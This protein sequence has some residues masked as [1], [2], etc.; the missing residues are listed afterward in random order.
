[1]NCKR[2]QHPISPFLECCFFF[3]MSAVSIQQHSVERS[4]T[5]TWVII[6]II[7]YYVLCIFITKI[8]I[9]RSILRKCTILSK[10]VH[11]CWSKAIPIFGFNLNRSFYAAYVHLPV[12]LEPFHCN[13]FTLIT[14]FEDLLVY[15][16]TL[17]DCS[18]RS[19]PTFSMWTLN[20]IQ[21]NQ[22]IFQ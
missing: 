16:N 18:S 21:C 9:Q 20:T 22:F 4:E 12:L 1:M 2:Y 6:L 13:N 7:M 5:L 14:V 8:I 19:Y 10:C 17:F 3:W 15:K 11:L